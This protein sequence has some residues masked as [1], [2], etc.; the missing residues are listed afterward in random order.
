METLLDWLAVISAG[1]ATSGRTEAV[2]VGT[3][4]EVGDGA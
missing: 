1:A 4:I 2:C 3:E